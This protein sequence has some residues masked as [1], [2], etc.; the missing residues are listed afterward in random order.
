MPADLEAN[1]RPVLVAAPAYTLGHV[2]VMLHRL[3]E[4]LLAVV[5]EVLGSEEAWSE[6]RARYG[7]GLA[8]TA[9]V[10]GGEGRG[11]VQALEGRELASLE[12]YL[13]LDRF[14]REV[15]ALVRVVAGDEVAGLVWT[16]LRQMQGLGHGR[17]PGP[18]QATGEAGGP[19]RLPG[20][21]A[22]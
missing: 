16:R 10:L 21:A 17:E 5:R 7:A 6:F 11:A 19:P 13:V 8:R 12:L 18:D 14:V 15:L 9:E 4:D 3:H 22:G 20:G 1:I 2:Q